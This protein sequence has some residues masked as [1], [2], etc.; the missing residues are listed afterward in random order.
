MEKKK[1]SNIQL[2]CLPR[3]VEESVNGKRSQ[4]TMCKILAHVEVFSGPSTRE[5]SAKQK[6]AKE[7]VLWSKINTSLSV[8]YSLNLKVHCAQIQ[9]F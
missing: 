4:Q 9:A 2:K 7:K 6:A 3:K 1:N 8:N 5:G